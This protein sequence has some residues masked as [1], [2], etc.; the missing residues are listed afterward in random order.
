MEFKTH[1]TVTADIMGGLLSSTTIPNS[2]LLQ[3]RKK[4]TSVTYKNYL[5]GHVGG[6]GFTPPTVWGSVK[7]EVEG[8]LSGSTNTV[9]VQK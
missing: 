6:V 4:S 8:F 9:E 5:Y 7:G 3:K 1:V 2:K